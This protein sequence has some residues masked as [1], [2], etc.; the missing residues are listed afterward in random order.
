[1]SEITDFDIEKLTSDIENALKDLF[2]Y[3]PNTI[4]KRVVRSC[5]I[6]LK[7]VVDDLS[8]EPQEGPE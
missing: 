2:E 1:M 6:R 3:G 4:N 7:R 5:M 8:V